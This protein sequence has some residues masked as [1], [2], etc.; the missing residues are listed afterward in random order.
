MIA[1][2]YTGL[3]HVSDSPE[4][5]ISI[6]LCCFQKKHFFGIIGGTESLH[7][8]ASVAPTVMGGQDLAQAERL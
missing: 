8:L 1:N 6:S 2:S 7:V 5:F 4:H 3:H